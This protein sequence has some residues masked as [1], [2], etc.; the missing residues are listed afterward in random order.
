M[1]NSHASELGNVSFSTAKPSDDSSLSYHLD[2][3]H[4]GD[5]KQYQSAKPLPP[6]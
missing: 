2:S 6:S 1:H 5:L 3:N 4:M